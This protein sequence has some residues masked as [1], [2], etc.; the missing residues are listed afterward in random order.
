MRYASIPLIECASHAFWKTLEGVCV[1]V[2]A[3][4]C[5][6]RRH[7][8]TIFSLQGKCY[9]CFQILGGQTGSGHKNIV[10]VVLQPALQM[11]L[12]TPQP[13]TQIEWLNLFEGRQKI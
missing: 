11:D 13:H 9:T 7:V 10:K 3:C 6:R 5:A 8:N 12:T 1:C 2:C 4:A